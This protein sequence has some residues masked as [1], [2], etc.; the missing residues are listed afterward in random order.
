M[1]GQDGGE[2]G[3]DDRA[4]ALHGG[5]NHGIGYPCSTAGLT[6]PLLEYGHDADGGCTIIG[7]FVYRGSEIPDLRG[8]YFYSDL[9]SGF[10]RS[11]V[12]VGGTATE[13]VDWNIIPPGRV[14]SFGEDA[15]KELYLM[16]EEGGVFRVARQ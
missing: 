9:C 7:G 6:L 1:N 3:Q 10:L 15:Q 5:L 13:R 4:G 11:F 12:A 8:R 16:T 14:L 2:G